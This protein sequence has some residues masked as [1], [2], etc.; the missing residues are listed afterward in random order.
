[1]DHIN[2]RQLY[3]VLLSNFIVN[4]RI[5]VMIVYNDNLPSIVLLTFPLSCKYNTDSISYF[6]PANGL[7]SFIKATSKF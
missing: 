2:I 5:W 4:L 3:E 6:F 7:F 1:M